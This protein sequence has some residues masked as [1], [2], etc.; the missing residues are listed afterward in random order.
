MT[1]Y[2]ADETFSIERRLV[3]ALVGGRAVRALDTDAY[4]LSMAQAGFPLRPETFTLTFRRGP[5]PWL[6]PFDLAAVVRE[7]RPTLPDSGEQS[8]LDRWGYG[9]SPDMEQALGAPVEVWA[10]PKGCW[11]G[12]REP[13]LVVS[14]TSLV[15]SWMEP[16]ALMLHYPIQVATAAR[17]GQRRF[18]VTCADEAAIVR[19][20][21]EA[22]GLGVEPEITIQEAAYRARVRATAL[23]LGQALGGQAQRA[24]EV[25]MRSATCLAQHRIALEE[26][27]R[28]GI[29]RTSN[30]GLAYALGL[31]PVGTTG[32]EH[33]QRY[34]DDVRAFRAIRDRRPGVPSYLFDT[35]DPIRLGIPAIETVVEETPTRP[36]AIRFDSGD[37][38]AQFRRLHDYTARRAAPATFIFEDGYDAARTLANERRVAARG[39]PPDRAWYGYGGALVSAPAFSPSTRDHVSA[40]WKLSESGGAARMKFSGTAGKASTPGR[41]CSFIRVRGDG[42]LDRL[43]GQ[44]GEEPPAGFAPLESA[45]E[46]V[47]DGRPLR[48]GESPATRRLIALAEAEREDA[49]ASA[50]RARTTA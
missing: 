7:L 19:L 37:Q 35:F 42:E 23:E 1:V 21:F 40:A 13:V 17:L 32:H 9:L 18:E 27:A 28:A 45:P 3:G 26:C 34:G 15:A 49:V 5:G 36:F 6:N 16:L 48:I 12:A 22:A 24:F 29:G 38:D 31:T 20:A 14:S 4:K 30:L 11:F 47:A 39:L 8:F 25:G 46:G 33:Q 10:V 50:R 43:I 41:P 44:K 2:S